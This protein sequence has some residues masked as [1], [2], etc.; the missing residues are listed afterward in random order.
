MLLFILS[1]K[2]CPSW[3]KITC[4]KLA[5]LPVEYLKPGPVTLGRHSHGDL[6]RHQIALQ[7]AS[8]AVGAP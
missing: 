5:V 2:I 1:L 4:F 8:I 6:G 3:H 7:N